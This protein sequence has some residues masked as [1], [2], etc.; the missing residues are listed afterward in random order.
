MELI[1]QLLPLALI[2]VVISL[3]GIYKKSNN[4]SI[5]NG[6][7]ITNNPKEDKNYNDLF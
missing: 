2:I 4:R 3:V 7:M 6:R 5:D 1:N